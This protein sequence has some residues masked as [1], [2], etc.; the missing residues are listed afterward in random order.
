MPLYDYRCH[1]C[2]DF[3]SWE[4]MSESDADVACPDCDR[5]AIRSVTGPSLALMPNNNRVANTRNEKS[6]DQP[7]VIT[8]GSQNR[9]G[10]AGHAHGGH[11]HANHQSSGHS[12]NQGR[13]WM[14]G[15]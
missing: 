12:H 6:A 2:G 9:S 4:S 14:I 7:E 3:R 1:D 15:H 5:P 8:K 11:C 13:P 10:S